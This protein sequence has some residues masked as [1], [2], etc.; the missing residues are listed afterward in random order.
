[1]P[2]KYKSVQLDFGLGHVG[3]CYAE[4][5]AELDRPGIPLVVLDHISTPAAADHGFQANKLLILLV[6]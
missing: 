4:E 5:A 3:N 6:S 1:M 2:S